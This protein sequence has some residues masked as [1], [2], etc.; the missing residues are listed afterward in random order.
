MRDVGDTESHPL[1][2]A[3][4]KLRVEIPRTT[5]PLQVSS[6]D[7]TPTETR[8]LLQPKAS[9]GLMERHQ[10]KI[11]DASLNQVTTVVQRKSGRP[12]TSPDNVPLSL[13]QLPLTKSIVEEVPLCMPLTQSRLQAHTITST[14]FVRVVL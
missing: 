2:T 1:Q 5:L 12:N 6:L 8:N 10:K 14:S 9:L 3:S 7:S 4:A 11:P 13:T